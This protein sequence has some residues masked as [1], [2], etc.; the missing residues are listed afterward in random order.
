MKNERLL[1]MTP[2]ILVMFTTFAF[3]PLHA[4]DVT[5]LFSGSKDEKAIPL[6]EQYDSLPVTVPAVVMFSTGATTAVAEDLVSGFEQ[7]LYL[8]M[9][10]RKIVK[11]VS[12]NTWLYMQY[13]KKKV[14]EPVSLLSK[15][16]NENYKAPLQMICKPY[17]FRTN[18]FFCMR[19][20]FYGIAGEYY[21]ID[22]FRLFSKPDEIPAVIE[23]CL[24]ELVIRLQ[25]GNR[26]PPRKRLL[27]E[28]FSLEI[29]KLIE[30]ESGEFEY[31]DAPFI[32]QGAVTLR[33]EDEFFSHICAYVFTTTGLYH[34]MISDDFSAFSD[35]KFKSSSYADYI[36]RGRVQLSDQMGVLYFTLLDASSGKEVFSIRYPIHEFSLKTIWDAY[37][38]ISCA[39]SAEVFDKGSYGIVSGLES[40][41]SIFYINNCFAG[42]DLLDGLIVQ[43]G[44]LPVLT[45]NIL[46]SWQQYE[47]IPK[48]K[49]RID[50]K[51]DMDAVNIFYVFYDNEC[52]L[53]T[54][55]D[56]EYLQNL[57][58]KK[59]AV[60]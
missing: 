4:F 45:G 21:P 11:P 43:R 2:I 41:G 32:Q 49:R 57:L 6:Q 30:L 14:Q 54:D 37:R 27:V 18:D 59:G 20:S 52:R 10:Q 9:I 16:G 17:L 39:V 26:S 24:D 47:S 33:S 28:K 48:E 40:K 22:V 12:L 50:M 15:I 36:V 38:K 35:N 13:S 19:V 3:F 25:E 56:G 7:E 31:I 46:Y 8:Q 5:G 55:R 58:N 1:K 51:R 60:E 29:K 42:W 34:S 23:A 44:L 53:F